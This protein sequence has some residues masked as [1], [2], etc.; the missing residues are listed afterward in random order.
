MD[1]RDRL[2]AYR[3][4][5]HRTAVRR[6]GCGVRSS[7]A[8]GSPRSRVRER[9]VGRG[10]GG[11]HDPLGRA[12]AALTERAMAYMGLAGLFW[13][14]MP[15]GFDV[16]VVAPRPMTQPAKVLVRAWA[17]ELRARWPWSAWRLRVAAQ[18]PAELDRYECLFWRGSE[19]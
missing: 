10:G 9:E 15:G 19:R 13:R 5:R 17:K 8:W 4:R 11:P 1:R 16:L 6:R 3:R 14:G 18:A 2:D 12:V 7:A